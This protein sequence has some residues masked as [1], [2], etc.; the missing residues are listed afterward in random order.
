MAYCSGLLQSGNSLVGVTVQSTTNITMELIKKLNQYRYSG[1]SIG[2]TARAFTLPV[3]RCTYY[4][5][6]I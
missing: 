4:G 6:D 3:I 1:D 5:T 2:V